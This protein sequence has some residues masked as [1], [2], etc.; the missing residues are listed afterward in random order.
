MDLFSFWMTTS[1]MAYRDITLEQLP[2]QMVSITKLQQAFDKCTPFDCPSRSR[3]ANQYPSYAWPGANPEEISMAQVAKV[4]HH[5]LYNAEYI[6]RF[7]FYFSGEK[8]AP[9]EVLLAYFTQTFV[10]T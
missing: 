2:S 8:V 10:K 4:M 9:Y 1:A 6:D 7:A 5:C 3:V